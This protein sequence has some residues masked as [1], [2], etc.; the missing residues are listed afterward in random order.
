[1]TL[2][3]EEL[4]SSALS[5]DEDE[6]TTK[7]TTGDLRLT[8]LNQNMGRTRSVQ[9]PV[10]EERGVLRQTLSDTRD[11]DHEPGSSSDGRRADSR[12]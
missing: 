5:T 12:L 4:K 8:V 6:E 10:L 3:Y 1:M 11:P 2:D 7:E 9:L